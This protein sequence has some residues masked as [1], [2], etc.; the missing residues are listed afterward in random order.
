M[1]IAQKKIHEL[2]KHLLELELEHY[3]HE[4]DF[5]IDFYEWEE[6]FGRSVYQKFES[7]TCDPENEF[8]SKIIKELETQ[9]CKD[10]EDDHWQIQSCDQGL[11]NPMMTTHYGDL[12]NKAFSNQMA[13]LTGTGI[14]TEMFS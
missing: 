14:Q 10:F 12:I 7:L 4:Q 9:I 8:N 11:Y 1:K 3:L 6:K 5:I 13:M 2:A